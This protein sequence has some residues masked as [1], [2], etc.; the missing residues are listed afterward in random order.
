M[1]THQTIRKIYD[2]LISLLSNE[3]FLF[4][5]LEK[6]KYFEKMSAQRALEAKLKLNPL[7]A[8]WPMEPALISGFCCDKWMRVLDSPWTGH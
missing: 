4:N 5:Q 6:A 3:I 2:I 7:R 8:R 1:K